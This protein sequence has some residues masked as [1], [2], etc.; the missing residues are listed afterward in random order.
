MKLPFL[1][2]L[3][4]LLCV[5]A[6]AQEDEDLNIVAV[7]DTR[8]ARVF[9]AW[10]A[11][12]NSGDLERHTRYVAEHYSVSELGGRGPEMVADLEMNQRET[13]GGGYDVYQVLSA[14]DDEVKLILRQQG[15]VGFDQLDFALDAK[16]PRMIAAAIFQP[17]PAPAEARPPRMPAER[18]AKELGALLQKM[19]EKER[20]SGVVLLAKDGKPLLEKAYGYADR[21]K[22]TP[23]KLDTK[24]N[25]GSM[26]KSFTAL[27]IA[28]L[29]AAGK[30]KYEDTIATLLPDYP[31][32][33]V[34]RKVTVHQLLTHTSGLG[35]YF[36][37]GYL[38]KK[39]TL[40]D[41]KDYLPL[42]ADKPL[43][44]EPGG[45][46]SYSNAGM[47]VAGL[48]VERVSGKDYFSYVREN[49]FKPAGM[50]DSDSYEKAAKV[51][52]LAVGYTREKG[53]LVP[54]TKWL[55]VRG[56]SAGGGYSTAP[57]LL[58]FAQGLRGNKLLGKEATLDLVRGKVETPRDAKYGYGFF[59]VLVDG[60]RAVGHGGGAPGISAWL[61][62]YWD[63]GYTVVVLAN[64]DPIADQI[65]KWVRE[66]I[67][68]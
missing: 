32:P 4:L 54:N 41:L 19:A 14:P 57:D 8:A 43:Q 48:I 9:Q 51:P 20:F 36:G 17:V 53:K 5:P 61:D 59:E 6:P 33:E 23:N 49:V 66:R 2:V 52:N 37:P 24:F 31:N 47:L 63:S 18:L 44:S 38:E 3:L 40:R 64:R 29:V 16:D 13:I 65:V 25:L 50:E 55:G 21:E 67:K 11:S 22:L 15:W 12:F 58:R 10:L 60:S 28:Q 30:M 1:L 68:Q 35:N 39:D 27:A 34:A 7:P 45:R 46:W 62:I 26:N 56:T 42:F